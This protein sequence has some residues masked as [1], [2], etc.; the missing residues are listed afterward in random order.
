MLSYRPHIDGLRTIAVLLVVL[1]HMDASFFSGGYLGVDIFFVISGF[2]ITQ[3]L[4]KD[5][6]TNGR[7][8][9]Y[10]FYLRRFK[11][12]YPALVFMLL[13]TTSAYIFWG[14]LWDVNLYL[15]SAFSAFFA[16]SNL[17][18]LFHGDNYFQ[19]DL[20]NPLT[21]TWSLGVEEQFYVLYPML[22]MLGL[23]VVRK[24][25][26][27]IRT[28]AYTILAISALLFFVFASGK[29]GL[30]SEF[31]FPFARFWELGIGCALSLLTM[32]GAGSRLATPLATF[33]VV[34]LIAMQFVPALSSIV[35]LATGLT[36]IATA[37]IV[38]AGLAQ[39]GLI[40]NFLS[41][42]LMV[43]FGKLSYSLYLWHL[44]VIYFANLY[45]PPALFPVVAFSVSVLCAMVSYH[46]VENPLRYSKLLNSFIVYALK[47]SPA[48]II[49]V[50]VCVGV[51]GVHPTR[52][53]INTGFNGFGKFIGDINYIEKNFALGE[54][55]Q[56]NFLPSS[57]STVDCNVPAE[58]QELQKGDESKTH[59][60]KLNDA[61]N[62]PLFYLVGDSHA[63][64][65][66]PAMD[67][68]G[69]V[70]NLLFKQFPSNMIV[71]SRAKDFN[72]ENAQ[73]MLNEQVQE[74]QALHAQFPRIYYV[75]SLFLT[76][77][78][79]QVDTIE[80]NL[81]QYI[82]SI[83]PFATIIFI[84]PT[85]VFPGGPQSCVLLQKH[86]SIAR[87]D[88]RAA[89]Q[90]IIDMFTRLDEAYDSVFVFDPYPSVCPDT[91]CRNY[92][93]ETDTLLY[94]DDDH[95]TPELST[96]IAPAFDVWWHNTFDGLQ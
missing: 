80:R 4:Y 9:I 41:R 12:L 25:K 1:F 55:I 71:A 42:P 11:R 47:L 63:L 27:S 16:S 56:P 82:E 15:K 85:P 77:Y 72:R 81:R 86:C 26:V 7:I 8:N 18:F 79:D 68:S 6:C 10:M 38:Y 3:S 70:Q 61:T 84:A 45:V 19:Q 83:D 69:E 53:A 33:G 34:I 75:T 21:H 93:R 20:I 90:P 96:Q 94:I 67:T 14:Y 32:E 44:P 24:Y 13:V 73:K 50:A 49:I 59:C 31:Y 23:M 54:R 87:A 39:T 95:I 22:L 5:Y 91:V 35:P 65:F 17:Y 36:V 74:V 89:Q 66:V 88:D 58:L 28:L 51:I 57:T 43:Y 30:L 2:V 62:S 29:G 52:D 64:H 60:L 37:G 48:V 92:I 76:P 46:F 40:T 78:K